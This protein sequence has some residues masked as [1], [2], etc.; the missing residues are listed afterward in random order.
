MEE[1]KKYPIREIQLCELEILKEVK[2]VCEKYNFTFYLGSGTLL[3]AVR[4]KGFIPWD[5]D[6]DI[7]MPYPDY[8]RF[9]KVAQDELG[10]NYYVQCSE[11]EE[12]LGRLYTKIRKN[13][14]VLLLADE[15]QNS[16]HHG[17]WID[18][19]PLI[20]INNTTEYRVKRIL[21]S[22]YSYLT[23]G[24]D[25]YAIARRIT[26]EKKTTISVYLRDLIRLLPLA[27]RLR[28]AKLLKGIIFRSHGSEISYIWGNLS[29]PM[30]E[31]IYGAGKDVLFEGV[32]FRAPVDC[33][34]YLKSTYGNYMQFPPE[35][36]RGGHW[37]KIIQ[38]D[39]HYTES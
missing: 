35:N 13:N 16:G 18:I 28:I 22:I 7:E 6:I 26:R 11:T 25:N 14:T 21:V 4:H 1:S 39:K 5:D 33:D 32:L 3:G 9:L 2:R 15:V 10:E 23:M 12:Q 17:V 19:F 24:N 27:I 38:L 29:S 31:S 37:P 34:A 20:H 36:E 30:P 8:A